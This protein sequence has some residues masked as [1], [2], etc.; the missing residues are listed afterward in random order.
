MPASSRRADAVPQRLSGSSHVPAVAVAEPQHDEFT[1]M[2]QSSPCY[3]CYE[4]MDSADGKH[5]PVVTSCGHV[6]GH[7]C[8]KQWMR[9]FERTK[10][11]ANYDLLATPCPSCRRKVIDSH[12]RLVPCVAPRRAPQLPSDVRVKNEEESKDE[13]TDPDDEHMAILRSLRATW[14]E[15][16]AKQRQAWAMYSSLEDSRLRLRRCCLLPLPV[17]FVNA[18]H[19]GS[20]FFLG[21]AASFGNSIQLVAFAVDCGQIADRLLS[22]VTEQGKVIISAAV[23]SIGEKNSAPASI[24][25]LHADCTTS[26]YFCE[27]GAGRVSAALGGQIGPLS[28]VRHDMQW[29]MPVSIVPVI[30]SA[31]G[32]FASCMA[33]YYDAG[34]DISVFVVFRPDGGVLVHGAGSLAGHCVRPVQVADLGTGELMVIFSDAGPEKVTMSPN[35]SHPSKLWWWRCMRLRLAPLTSGVLTAMTVSF[36]SGYFPAHSAKL[37]VSSLSSARDTVSVLFH[38]DAGIRLLTTPQFE[39]DVSAAGMPAASLLLSGVKVFGPPERRFTPSF[40]LER[41]SSGVSL[42]RRATSGLSSAASPRSPNAGKWSDPCVTRTA[43]RPREQPVFV[44]IDDDDDDDDNS[45]EGLHQEDRDDTL[46]IYS[47]VKE[48]ELDEVEIVGTSRPSGCSSGLRSTAAGGGSPLEVAGG[49]L[50][51]SSAAASDATGLLTVL[52]S[53]YV[54]RHEPAIAALGPTASLEPRS[55]ARMIALLDVPAHAA[56]AVCAGHTAVAVFTRDAIRFYS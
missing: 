45:C 31:P 49:V 28:L 38:V 36:I 21:T 29:A 15:L 11:N 17:D 4:T 14:R 1:E 8:Y 6:F 10:C 41:S 43:K 40:D 18:E 19:L 27:L 2:L 20:D 42:D 13:R 30:A 5:R 51:P 37:V 23:L 56:A 12:I 52:R 26:L 55:V 16:A 9:S 46:S 33:S 34:A 35:A 32:R 47:R 22:P 7:S 48:S 53:E 50:A 44:I 24:V 54:A 39:A 25:V 3:I